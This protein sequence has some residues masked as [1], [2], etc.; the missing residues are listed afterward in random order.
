M[1]LVLLAE[2]G[3]DQFRIADSNL[4]LQRLDVAEAADPARDV[5]GAERRAFE[6]GHD[7]DHVLGVV[8]RDHGHAKLLR[9]EAEGAR[10]E[11]SA[12]DD[13]RIHRQAVGLGRRD[14]EEGNRVDGRKRAGR[15]HRSLDPLLAAAGE[16]RPQVGEVAELRPVHRGFGAGRQRFADLR[17][18]DADLAR[19]NLDPRVPQ[20]HVCRPELETDSRHEQFGLP[21]GFPGERD[22]G[23]GR[24]VPPRGPLDDQPDFGR[25]DHDE[26][27]RDDVERES[28]RDYKEGLEQNSHLSCLQR[29]RSLPFMRGCAQT[30]GD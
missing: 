9:L 1:Q 4:L 15:E 27:S 20:D 26:R 30:A 5:G 23:V 16:K 29:A 2:Q 8:R 6:R 19:R 10:L 21:A 3:L 28:S 24:V 17:D 25:A 12:G 18:D 22:R 14:H 13:L 11:R 7:A